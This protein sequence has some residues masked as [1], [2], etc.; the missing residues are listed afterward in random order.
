MKLT[1]A[2]RKRVFLF[3]GTLIILSWISLKIVLPALPV[4]TEAFGCS[5]HLIKI[6]VS[7]YLLSFALS[8]PVWG[9]VEQRTDPKRTLTISFAVAITGFALSILSPNLPVYMVGR[10]IQGFGMGAALPIGRTLMGDAY[11]HRQ[12]SKL[13]GIIAGFAAV[14]PAVAPI[15]GSFLLEWTGWR[16]IF[17]FLLLSSL[18]WI[19]AASRWLPGTRSAGTG[20]GGRNPDGL[21]A[22]FGSIL[23]SREFWGFSLSYA[24]MT[25]S[26]LGYYSAMPY[27]FHVQ[28]GVPRNVFSY[29]AIPTVG[30]YV[31]GLT[32][33]SFMV[34][35]REVEEMLIMGLVI[36]AL[37]VATSVVFSILHFAGIVPVIVLF[38]ALAFAAGIVSP[39]ANAGVLSA[40]REVAPPASAMT[41]LVLFG[42]ASLA[43]LIAMYIT[44]T[45]DLWPVTVYLA[46]SSAVGL[47]AGYFWMWRPFCV[48]RRIPI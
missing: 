29:L 25:G 4:L 42:T 46:V 21:R 13:L 35:K 20:S 5:S 9:S 38:S 28:L 31:A 44:V 16:V 11:R 22:V 47:T 10:T 2:D 43:S 41:A 27:W 18:L 26:L 32:F 3:S 8:Q 33:S 36:S 24:S 14:M 23:V 15:I 19:L 37:V 6:S 48:R 45:G 7:L 39:N 12:L 40:F 1:A 34:R 30:L 17:G